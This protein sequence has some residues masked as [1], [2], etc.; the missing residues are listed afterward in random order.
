MANLAENIIGSLRPASLYDIIYFFNFNVV[1]LK[2]SKL[3][4]LEYSNDN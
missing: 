4:Y 3:D 1:L 2:V